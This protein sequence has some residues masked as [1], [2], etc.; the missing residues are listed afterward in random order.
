[1]LQ[2][3]IN[4]H[5][6]YNTLECIRGQAIADD[7]LQIAE[8]THAL[9]N[10][11]RYNISNRREIVSIKEEL[12]NVQNYMKIQQYRFQGR[13]KMDIDYDCDER[14]LVDAVLPKLSLQPLVENA[15]IH[16]FKHIMENAHIDISIVQSKKNLSIKVSD[17][18]EGIDE[19]T[20]MQIRKRLLQNSYDN[21]NPQEQ[22]GIAMTNVN[23]RIVL[24]FGEQYGLT[25]NS[26]KNAGTDI[27]LHIP[28]TK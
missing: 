16:G 19:E 9:S 3:Q 23:R 22:H 28:C 1:M 21:H 17:N 20:L 25:I 18:G 4:P 11:Y 26:I 6:L 24:L 12:D 8:T 7:E 14:V 5:F 10:Y 27:E 2:A 13:F 15:I